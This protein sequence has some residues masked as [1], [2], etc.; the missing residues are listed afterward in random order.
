MAKIVSKTYGDALFAVAVEEGKVDAF[1]DAATVVQQVLDANQEFCKLLNHPEIVKEN[2]IKML[3]DTFLERIPKE[4]VGFMILLVDKGRAGEIQ[5]CLEYFID[6]VKEEKKIGK[7]NIVTAFNL[8]DAQKKKVEERLIDTTK[9]ESFEMEYQVDESLIGG[10]VIRIGDRVVD[11]SIKTKLYDLSR[12][13]R[14]I[15]V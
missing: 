6:L 10:M 7:A 14:N 13:L 5:A 12:E 4:L 3:E 11:S 9:Y 1:F 2:K 15:Q 8:S